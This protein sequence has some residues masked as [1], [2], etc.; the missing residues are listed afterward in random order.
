[1]YDSSR[2]KR[3][4]AELGCLQHTW[5]QPH[6]QHPLGRYL[7]SELRA[8]LMA[9]QGYAYCPLCGAREAEPHRSAR[10]SKASLLGDDKQLSD[11]RD[12][13]HQPPRPYGAEG[14][15]RICR[16]KRNMRRFR[17]QFGLS[18]YELADLAGLSRQLIANTERGGSDTVPGGRALMRLAW[19]MG[20]SIDALL[21][22][23]LHF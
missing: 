22:D 18:Q 16:L 7:H 13:A 14:S 10:I 2:E 21:F 11:S 20:V 17:K 5:L 3:M 4:D 12:T 8:A 19:V 6:T 15:A 1:M 23:D 9:V